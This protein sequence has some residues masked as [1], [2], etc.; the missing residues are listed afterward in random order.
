M[1]PSC[2]PRRLGWFVC[3]Y[4]FVGRP[5]SF[6][7]HILWVTSNEGGLI[8]LRIHGSLRVITKRCPWAEV[9]LQK[10]SCNILTRSPDWEQRYICRLYG[11]VIKYHRVKQQ[12]S[13]SPISGM[14]PCSEILEP[15]DFIKVRSVNNIYHSFSWRTIKTSINTDFQSP[16][17]YKAW[18][19]LRTSFCL[20]FSQPGICTKRRPTTMVSPAK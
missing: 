11:A 3:D 14:H 13:I 15:L 1:W 7:T 6:S 8:L 4:L 2:L 9:D 19:V 18:Q 17:S 20:V 12:S 10:I 5:L 16:T